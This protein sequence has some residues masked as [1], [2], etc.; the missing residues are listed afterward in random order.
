VSGVK[1]DERVVIN[2]PD[3][4][5]NGQVVRVLATGKGAAEGGK[6]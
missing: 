3:S 5:A 1:G 2:P 6:Q 4:L